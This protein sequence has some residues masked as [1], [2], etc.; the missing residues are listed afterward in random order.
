[1]ERFELD[2]GEWVEDGG[3]E[4]LLISGRHDWGKW[5]HSESMEQ[6]QRIKTYIN[7]VWFVTEGE[8]EGLQCICLKHT[9]VWDSDLGY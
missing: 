3:S 9:G 7:N 5:E 2:E 6:V 1:M 8:R 4:Q